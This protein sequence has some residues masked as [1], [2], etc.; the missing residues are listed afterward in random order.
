MLQ[1]FVKNVWVFTKSYYIQIYQE[2]WIG[3]GLM[4]FI[5]YK[6]RSDDKRSKNFESCTCSWSS[7]ASF[8]LE[9]TSAGTSVWL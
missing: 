9:Y 7:L 3:M 6:I 4:G 8:T 1:S 2:I 5:I